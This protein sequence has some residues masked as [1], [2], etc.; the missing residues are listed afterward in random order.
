MTTLDLHR[1]FVIKTDIQKMIFLENHKLFVAYCKDMTLRIYSDNQYGFKEVSVN[2][3][4]QTV[5]CMAYSWPTATFVWGGVG[6]VL[7]WEVAATLVIHAH[8]NVYIWDYMQ[9]K[10]EVGEPV[11]GMMFVDTDEIVY[12]SASTLKVFQLNLF[13]QLVT[14]LQADI[15]DVFSLSSSNYS[16]RLVVTGS[17]EVQVCLLHIR[18][19]N[20]TICFSKTKNIGKV[21]MYELHQGDLHHSEADDHTDIVNGI[22]CSP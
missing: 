8:F 1:K 13:Y 18:M 10:I 5:L 21:H 11:L 2:C 19:I 3:C 22:T 15:L 4:R 16:N 9:Q 17:M 20:S 12:W 7:H 6:C 14:G